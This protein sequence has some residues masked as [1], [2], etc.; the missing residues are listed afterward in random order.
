MVDTR[1]FRTH[2]FWTG[3]VITSQMPYLTW[4]TR[5][6]G[7][8]PVGRTASP[9]PPKNY[10]SHDPQ[11]S[12]TPLIAH[13]R[14]Q[15]PICLRLLFSVKTTVDDLPVESA[16]FITYRDTIFPAGK[17]ELLQTT[18]YPNT[19]LSQQ[20]RVPK[21]CC[22]HQQL[23][24]NTAKCAASWLLLLEAKKSLKWAL[25]MKRLHSL[26]HPHHHLQRIPLQCAAWAG[27]LC[28]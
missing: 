1:L 11:M 19:K 20:F 12:P 13:G 15:N 18:R 26:Q 17:R 21:G 24:W 2:C 25:H 7:F 22:I 16:S 9:G 27:G 6:R 10:I 14:S 3:I 5:T 23:P 28:R 8:L 4:H